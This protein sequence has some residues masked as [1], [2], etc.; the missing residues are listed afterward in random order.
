VE[1]R[2]LGR[3]G[4]QSTLA[5]FGAAA[6]W[7]VT[8]WTADQTMAQVIEAGVNH[9][10]VAPSYGK[11][12]KRLRP[13]LEQERDRFFLGCKTTERTKAGAAREL[14]ES[15]E[16]LGVDRFDL[17]QLHAV[18]S[19][20]Q[21]DRATGPGGALEAILEAREEGLLDYIGITGHGLEVAA[22]FYKALERFDFDTVMFPVNFVLYGNPAYRASSERLL[23]RCQ[24]INAGVMVIKAVARALWHERPRTHSSWYEPFDQL[25][26][27]QPA[28]NFSLSQPG[29]TGLCTAGDV[30]VLPLFLRACADYQPLT[31]EEQAELVASAG[32]YEP[33]FSEAHPTL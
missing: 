31:P 21:L 15:L 30:K 28:V 4:H 7:D 26:E 13:W 16:R 22:V 29:V 32:R 17:Y 8:Q 9:I 25:E 14:R 19:L 5:I 6:F 2:T 27:I 24:E 20:E 3:T 33:I 11:A 23:Q 10:D 1:T 18:D 12:E